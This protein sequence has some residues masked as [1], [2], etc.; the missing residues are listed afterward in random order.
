MLPV[1]DTPLN[2]YCKNSTSL[3]QSLSTS[4]TLNTTHILYVTT[5][6]NNTQSVCHTT[7]TSHNSYTTHTQTAYRTCIDCIQHRDT[8][9]FKVIY[10]AIQHIQKQELIQASLLSR[11]LKL[12]RITTVGS[13]VLDFF[14]SGKM[15]SSKITYIRNV[16]DITFPVS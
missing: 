11:L 13:V 15:A 8:F 14:V 16:D 12:T 1:Y 2:W 5:L 6:V 10:A 3:A 4:Q 7:C 9:V